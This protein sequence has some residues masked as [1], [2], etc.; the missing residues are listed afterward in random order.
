MDSFRAFVAEQRDGAV[1]RELRALEPAELPDG[2][3]TVRVAFS[4]VNYKD[5]LAT[6]PGAGVAQISP[7]VPGIDLAGDVTESSDS[8]FSEGDQVIVQGY[9]LGV[10]H[11]GGYA[12]YARVPADWVVPMPSGLDPR[13]AMALGT[14]G[15]TA[16]QSVHMLEQWG[17]APEHGP[18][19][20][21]GATGGVGSV[22][23]GILAERGY[24]V[25]ASTGKESEHDYLR[26]LGASEVLSREE[27][28]P[29]SDRPLEKQRWAA[30]VDPV[31]G[32]AL[33]YALRTM[34][35]GGATAVSG[36]TGGVKLET[37]VLPFIL[38][39]VAVIGVN[40]VDTPMELRREVWERLGG[41]LAPRGLDS[42][43]SEVSMEEL[44]PVL[45]SILEGGVRGRTVVR[46]GADL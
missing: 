33:A 32:A 22:A 44:E 20:V 29:E 40:S 14:A 24:E 2:E 17:L 7:L 19:L 26:A 11:H 25:A 41:D 16:A 6:S 43:V 42:M 35:Y 37:T 23:V 46:V 4:D 31:G 18:V 13:R 38:R 27:T 10:A 36:M 34:R 3:V 28:S 12:E 30:A 1:V 39:G 45:D 8:R 5:A 21:L 15:Y 9:E